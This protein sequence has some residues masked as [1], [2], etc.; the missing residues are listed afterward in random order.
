MAGKNNF[1]PIGH[2]MLDSRDSSSNSGI[3]GDLLG[4]VQRDIQI[5]PDKDLLTLQVGGG[6]VSN[7]LLGH[8]DH[9]SGGISTALV[10]GSE[11]GA[12]VEGEERVRG[13]SG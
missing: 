5:G 13:R 2:Q 6:E 11:V 7:A 9:P 12:D 8:A 10:E 4:I 1:S 3:I